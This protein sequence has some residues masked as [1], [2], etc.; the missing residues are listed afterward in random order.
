MTAITT[1]SSGQRPGDH[2]SDAPV[3]LRFSGRL[4]NGK[5][6]V[7]SDLAVVKLAPDTPVTLLLDAHYVTTAKERR[8]LL[9]R[10]DIILLPAGEMLYSPRPYRPYKHE[11]QLDP[12]LL[13]YA[14]N[15][16]AQLDVK[17][18]PYAWMNLLWMEIYLL[19]PLV[20]STREHGG[21]RLKSCRCRVPWLDAQFPTLNQ[22]LAAIVR[23][24]E[25]HRGSTTAN[26][27]QEVFVAPCGPTSDVA[28]WRSLGDYAS[29][30]PRATPVPSP[31]KPVD[32]NLP[33]DFGG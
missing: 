3:Q 19:D 2:P 25:P 23:L 21:S 14:K 13:A 4:S 10:E 30:I 32:V 24:C 29:E 20:L 31:V 18:P 33:L 27:M 16:W 17:H 15:V 1:Y 7:S 9:R 11:I 28:S 8:R 22:A 26:A 12:A 5:L 6:V